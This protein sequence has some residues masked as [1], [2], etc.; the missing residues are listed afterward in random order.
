LRLPLPKGEGWGEGEGS[1]RQPSVHQ[2]ARYIHQP[3]VH[4]EA[5]AGKHLP[6]PPRH[7]DGYFDLRLVYVQ[8]YSANCFS[9][10]FDADR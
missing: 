6:D 5:E 9:A 7:I 8:A 3:T 2:S 4:G 10:C 1:L